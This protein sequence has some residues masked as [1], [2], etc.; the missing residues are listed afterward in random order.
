MLASSKRTTIRRMTNFRSW[1]IPA[2]LLLVSAGFLSLGRW[3]LDRAEVNRNIE[4]SFSQADGMP[5]LDLALSAVS[6]E[7]LRYRRITLTGHYEP[8]VQILLDNMTRDGR[9]GYEVLTPFSVT[10]INPAGDAGGADPWVMVNRGWV[11]ASYDRSELPDVALTPVKVRLH[12]RIDSLPRAGLDL[13]EPVVPA[14]RSVVVLSY[15]DF[16]E[17]ETVLGRP[18]YRFQVLLDETQVDGFLRDWGPLTGRAER[19]TAYA[20]QWF[21]LAALALAI[22]IGLGF[23]G[24]RKRSGAIE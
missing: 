23:N 21:A 5:A 11:P 13:G 19:N 14:E 17:L 10:D 24:Y 16:D 4:R 1:L 18:L 22:T 12:G 20:V 15:P 3:Q 9:A 2:A 7:E 8:R 6:V